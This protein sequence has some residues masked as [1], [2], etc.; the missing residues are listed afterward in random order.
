MTTATRVEYRR[1]ARTDELTLSPVGRPH[2]NVSELVETLR[3]LR[4][5]TSQVMFS[6]TGS[7]EGIADAKHFMVLIS[8]SSLNSNS[9][10]SSTRE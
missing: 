7:E 10:T 9:G 3:T 6:G 2:T 8:K 5:N 4:E 1:R